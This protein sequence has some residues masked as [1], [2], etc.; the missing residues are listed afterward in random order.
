MAKT[1]REVSFTLASNSSVRLT[2]T[3]VIDGKINFQVS[4]FGYDNEDDR[5]QASHEL[6]WNN[7]L[8]NDMAVYN[9]DTNL[10]SLPYITNPFAVGKHIMTATIGESELYTSGTASIDTYI[11]RSPKAQFI[12]RG[13]DDK[14]HAYSSTTI[15]DIGS[16]TLFTC[17]C[18]PDHV[19]LQHS[20][21]VK[22]KH[23][24]TEY[25]QEITR[26]IHSYS[27]SS[28]EVGTHNITLAYNTKDTYWTAGSE[29]FSLEVAHQKYPSKISFFVGSDTSSTTKIM[30]IDGMS[31]E[32]LTVKNSVR[33]DIP[34]LTSIPVGAL[35]ISSETHSGTST[36]YSVTPASNTAKQYNITATYPLS[37]DYLVSS[38]T[39]VVSVSKEKIQPRIW[40][41]E[42]ND[43]N[44]TITS[45]EY[46]DTD[47]TN[48]GVGIHYEP[49]SIAGSDV[50]VVIP[51]LQDTPVRGQSYADMS[52]E[53]TI[54]WSYD[55][56]GKGKPPIPA[57]R[58]KQQA[59]IEAND[60]YKY[61][62]AFLDRII[63]L[64]PT[65]QF[66]DYNNS[67]VTI[68]SAAISN[69]D[70]LSLNVKTNMNKAP[71]YICDS[72]ITITSVTSTGTTHTY[73]ISGSVVDIFPIQ[74]HYEADLNSNTAIPNMAGTSSNFNLEILQHRA[75]STVVFYTTSD[76]NTPRTYLNFNDNENPVIIVKNSIR[77]DTPTFNSLILG[78]V[79]TSLTGHTDTK[80]SFSLTA[81]MEGNHTL[82][83]VYPSK[84]EYE[85]VTGNFSVTISHQ[86]KAPVLK[87]CT[88]DDE[89]ISTTSINI[90][91]TLFLKIY[92]NEG[93]RPD[94]SC[95]TANA[96]S[97][98]WTDSDTTTD[99]TYPYV[100]KYVLTPIS[101]GTFTL[102]ASYP[103]NNDYYQLP[104]Q[105]F[106]LIIVKERRQSEIKIVKPTD[107]D[108]LIS[109]DT[110]DIEDSYTILVLTNRND[111]PDIQNI[112][113]TTICKPLSKTGT[114]FLYQ[115]IPVTSGNNKIRFSYSNDDPDY[116]GTF[117]QFTLRVNR[118]S[119]DIYS[120]TRLENSAYVVLQRTDSE[121]FAVSMIL[122]LNG[123][124]IY[125][126]E[127]KVTQ[128]LKDA[129]IE[130]ADQLE[131]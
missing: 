8:V 113:G 42:R 3:D 43:D 48:P 9:T 103:A 68:S 64:T 128:Q 54:L 106:T 95:T 47:T 61:A 52:G 25:T 84:P 126:D 27:I 51:G 116:I 33:T 39:I 36:V 7:V 102:N 26:Y 89:I 85:R 55:F 2:E 124:V 76:T 77:S 49:S 82:Q 73:N 100:Y 122:G 37:Y 29:T 23:L 129:V 12:Y 58:Y 19:N 69:V 62:E 59:Y 88:E 20:S 131:S 4:Y 28:S 108:T 125:E 109:Y 30:Y 87:Y 57:G 119:D 14:Y 83:A 46:A 32:T 94:F 112:I 99:I 17:S 31:S 74:F 63:D 120:D 70:T 80:T 50:L 81:N 1:K 86:K 6:R 117:V 130:K 91:D 118:Y 121:H 45:H 75:S 10:W 107:S 79:S 92:T 101:S 105:S 67:S 38:D 16:T 104:D 110:M 72:S 15:M 97:I 24:N 35:K 18:R 123:E 34:T 111:E 114:A 71:E 22:S 11:Y 98:E 53:T 40:F 60:T 5:K 66:Y 21:A 96:V 93:L 65:F 90:T 127:V 78:A 13:D 41:T 56:E 44:V 115:L